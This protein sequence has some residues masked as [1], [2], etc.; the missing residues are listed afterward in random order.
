MTVT[1][2]ISHVRKAD[3]CSGG[4]RRWFKSYGFSW[5]DFLQNG[6]S[7]DELEATGDPLALKVVAIARED[8]ANGR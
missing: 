3:L 4:A 8:A 5:N 2:K 7:A 6:K 1:V